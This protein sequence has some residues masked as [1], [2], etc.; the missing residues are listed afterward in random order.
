MKADSSSESHH[1][2]AQYEEK[3]VLATSIF[4]NSSGSMPPGPFS[5]V[6][7]AASPTTSTPSKISLFANKSSDNNS[8]GFVYV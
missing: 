4:Q 2:S 7:H 5:G 6:T 1:I 8:H 3:H